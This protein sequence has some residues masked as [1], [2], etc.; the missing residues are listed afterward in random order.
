MNRV[1][2]HF[3]QWE[4]IKCPSIFFISILVFDLD[5]EL[6]LNLGGWSLCPE[7]KGLIPRG[8]DV[9]LGGSGSKRPESSPQSVSFRLD[10]SICLYLGSLFK[11]T[12]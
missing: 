3:A 5:A 11:R 12:C 8:S 4:N 7:G 9:G 2:S 10:T 6:N 1:E